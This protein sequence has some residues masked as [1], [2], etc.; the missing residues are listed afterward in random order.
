[1][2]TTIQVQDETKA[3]LDTLKEYA[4]QT[5]DELIQDLLVLKEED[6]LELSKDTKKAIAA[7]RDDVKVGRVY[8]TKQL[9]AELGL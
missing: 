6:A 3:R 8:T 9:I 2:A 1:M 5:Y 4:R 7:A